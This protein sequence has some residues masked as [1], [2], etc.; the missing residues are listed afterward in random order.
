MNQQLRAAKLQIKGVLKTL[1]RLL[2]TQRIASIGIYAGMLQ[3]VL[4]WV[5]P[6]YQAKILLIGLVFWGVRI[7]YFVRIKERAI[8]SESVFMFCADLLGVFLNLEGA[9]QAAKEC[10]AIFGS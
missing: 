9:D 4:L 7:P 5:F 3:Y 6:A 1:F 10:L 2:A 8:V